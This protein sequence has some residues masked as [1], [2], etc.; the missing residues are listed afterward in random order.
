MNVE[1]FA[2]SPSCVSGKKVVLWADDDNTGSHAR[3]SGSLNYT[4]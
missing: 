4:V 3:R 2:I 1:G